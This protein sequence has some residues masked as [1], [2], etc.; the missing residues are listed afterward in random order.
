M[1]EA[2]LDGLLAAFRD[3]S[4]R[5]LARLLTFAENGEY[6]NEL[7]D[8][9]RAQPGHGLVVGITGAPGAGKSTLLA[10]LVKFLRRKGESVC[11]LAC[12][13]ASPFSGGAI[14][15]DRVRMDHDPG[16]SG[17]FIRSSS[18]RGA[19]QAIGPRAEALIRLSRS[20]GFD[21][22][23]VETV[24]A[25]QDE[26]AIRDLVDVLIL[27]VTPM[28]GDDVQWEKAGVLE[29]SD[30]VVLNKGDLPGADVALAS[31]KSTLAIVTSD[32]QA[33]PPVVKVTATT[34][35]G[36]DT[37]WE[38]VLHEAGQPRSSR[39]LTDRYRLFAA[40]ERLLAERFRSAA[41]D[42]RVERL[43]QQVREE[44]L[45]REAAAW[46][47]LDILRPTD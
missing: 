37:L 32:G 44:H 33:P 12:D 35:E 27:V 15:G 14:L 10:A 4:R 7:A 19:G 25:G 45:N 13:P 17:V 39:R 42:E 3:G 31:L 1:A 36:I 28:A 11:V 43:L 38:A 20:F 30:I 9:A 5:A 40:L 26:F 46:Q 22:I 24:G 16:D 23:L 8:L 47:L 2:D 29:A 21:R 34:A 41:K 18:A 6:T